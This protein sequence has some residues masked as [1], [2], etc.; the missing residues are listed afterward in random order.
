LRAADENKATALEH[1][2]LSEWG[3]MLSG[4]NGAYIIDKVKSEVDSE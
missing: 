1:W 4:Y 3:E 2:F